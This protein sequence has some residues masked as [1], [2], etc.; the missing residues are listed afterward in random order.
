MMEKPVKFLNKDNL[1]LFGVVH[2]PID[3]VDQKDKKGIIFVHSG[4]EGRIGYGRQY[5]NYARRLCQEGFYVL[6]FD[7]HGMGDSEGHIP[8]CSMSEFWSKIQTG[9]YI[10]DVL[11]AIE[12]FIHEEGIH[13]ITLIGLCAG[14]VSAL[15][16]AGKY[17]N[18]DS[19]ILIGIPVLIDDPTVDYQGEISA[20][21]YRSNLIKKIISFESWKRFMTLKADYSHIFQLAV[22]WLKKELKKPEKSSDTKLTL[23]TDRP[24]FNRYILTSFIN[25]ANRGKRV[26]FIYGTNDTYFKEFQNEFQTKYLLKNDKYYDTY[27]VY[28]IEKANHMLT[29]KKWQDDAIEKILDWLKGNHQYD[30]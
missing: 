8:N 20:L 27:E 9:L 6:R 14:A 19:L 13:K 30:S 5:V 15:L 7:P 11:T 10:D 12:F 2:T 21:D 23:N 26:L 28:T 1:Q 4:D 3:G 17:S 29:Q 22:T 24:D 25:L 18:V 16:T